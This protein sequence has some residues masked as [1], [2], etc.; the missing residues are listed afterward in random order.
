M[1][2]NYFENS[3]KTVFYFV[4]WLQKKQGAPPPTLK[5]DQKPSMGIDD[6]GLFKRH[7]RFDSRITKI[8]EVM[9]YNMSPE[10]KF[11]FSKNDYF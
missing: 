2:K 6:K 3:V 4:N 5:I 11:F 7:A 1:G 8:R 9:G 10:R